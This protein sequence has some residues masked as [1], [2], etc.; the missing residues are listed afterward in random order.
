MK[1]DR[2]I[3]LVIGTLAAALLGTF[4][5]IEF[6]RISEVLAKVTT[7]SGRMAAIRMAT[8]LVMGGLT[9]AAAVWIAVRLVVHAAAA[10]YDDVADRLEQLAI[11]DLRITLPVGRAA[12]VRRLGLAVLAV[13]NRMFEQERELAELQAK[14]DRLCD[15]NAEERRML[16]RMVVGQMGHFLQTP[17]RPS[18]YRDNRETGFDIPEA[19]DRGVQAAPDGLSGAN[20]SA[21][22][23]AAPETSTVVP[24]RPGPGDMADL[25]SWS[26]LNLSA[27]WTGPESLQRRKDSAAG[28]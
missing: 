7:P 23:G 28:R 8:M 24:L 17:P 21:G 15:D 5:A 22:G 19:P 13:R 27:S 18:L 14:N 16:L 12:G 3:T 6:D 25:D 20:D 4:A 10:P 1:D 2:L 9:A 26:A 11:G